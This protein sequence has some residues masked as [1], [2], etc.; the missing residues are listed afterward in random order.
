MAVR[1]LVPAENAEE[2]RELFSE[3]EPDDVDPEADD[4]ELD[5]FEEFDDFEELDDEDELGGRRFRDDE[6]DEAEDDD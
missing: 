4:E 1:F 5:D 3:I 2:A 6:L